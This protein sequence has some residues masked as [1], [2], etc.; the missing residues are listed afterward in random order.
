MPAVL[1]LQRCSCV[2][3]DALWFP[4]AYGSMPCC[5]LAPPHLCPARASLQRQRPGAPPARPC[6]RTAAGAREAAV[7]SPCAFPLG[8][9]AIK[10]CTLQAKGGGT[11]SSGP[12]CLPPCGTA[13]R[14]GKQHSRQRQ[15]CTAVFVLGSRCGAP[16]CR[17]CSR[18][19]C[20]MRGSWRRATRRCPCLP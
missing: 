9:P 13:S 12:V 2:P 14:A 11:S 20:S 15:Q 19:G 17:A 7:C 3:G 8:M 6:R 18:H 5:C 4:P 1:A 10:G 16:A